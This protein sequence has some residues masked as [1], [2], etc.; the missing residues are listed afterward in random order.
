MPLAALGLML[1]FTACEE[2]SYVLD[3][4]SL[5]Y[6]IEIDMAVEQKAKIYIDATETETLPIGKAQRA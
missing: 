6:S 3:S 4:A 5:M 1:G 2:E